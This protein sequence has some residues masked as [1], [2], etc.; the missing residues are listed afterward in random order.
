M[1]S[2]LNT[3]LPIWVQVRMIKAR[4]Q[5]HF[6]DVRGSLSVHLWSHV[7]QSA[8]A[9]E[10]QL[11]ICFDGQAQVAQLEAHSCRQ[12][13]VFGFDVPAAGNHSL[14]LQLYMSTLLHSVFQPA[15]APH[16]MASFGV[17]RISEA[18][19]QQDQTRAIDIV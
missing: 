5:P 3:D 16:G 17:P 6:I 11:F 15:L 14:P 12:K 1:H 7:V 10:G 2:T 4:Q 18:N 9:S 13:D 8:R 19:F